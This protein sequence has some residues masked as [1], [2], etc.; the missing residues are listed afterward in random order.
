MQLHV[1]E[2]ITLTAGQAGTKAN[3][4]NIEGEPVWKASDETVVDITPSDDGLSAVVMAISPG[5]AR[6]VC[7]ARTD[8]GTVQIGVT[9]FRVV[10]EAPSRDEP[11]PLELPLIAT[12]RA[13]QA[14]EDNPAEKPYAARVAHIEK[15]E[16]DEAARRLAADKEAAKKAAPKAEPP[17][18]PFVPPADDP[19][20]T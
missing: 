1:H 2:Q 7:R 9:E 14:F 16:K 20:K 10:A 5:P 12:R 6:V 17:F 18:A 4:A 8:Q 19:A 3:P 11:A 13:H 15:A